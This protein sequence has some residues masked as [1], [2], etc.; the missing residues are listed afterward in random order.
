MLLLLVRPLML[1]LVPLMLP[2]IW[3]TL[4]LLR[5][6]LHLLRHLLRTWLH[7]LFLLRQSVLFRPLLRPLLVLTPRSCG[8]CFQVT[9]RFLTISVHYLHWFYF[10]STCLW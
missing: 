4:L 9:L 3:L 6:T 1:P 2:L 10:R 5:L 7:A 8:N